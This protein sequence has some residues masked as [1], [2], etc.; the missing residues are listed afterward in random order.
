[1]FDYTYDPDEEER[2]R[3]LLGGL[4]GGSGFSITPQSEPSAAPSEAP[5]GA[6]QLQAPDTSFMQQSGP[7]GYRPPPAAAPEFMQRVQSGHEFGV[8]DIAM[9]GG[10]LAALLGG[11]KNGGSIAGA[12]AGS[13]GQGIIGEM[14]NRNQRNAEIDQYNNKLAN[15]NTEYDRWKADQ[16]AQLAFGNLEARKRGM[17]NDEAREKRIAER[18]AQQDDPESELNRGEVTQAER[19]ARARSGVSIEEA[20]KRAD[21]EL[22]QRK[23]LT[24]LL[25]KGGSA[26]AGHAAPAGKG[27]AK[28]PKEL[29]PEQALKRKLA[30]NA[31]RGMED[32]SVDPLTGKPKL[33]TDEA[34]NPIKPETPAARAAREKADLLRTPIP[35]SV[36]QDEDAWNAA[37][38][39]GVERRNVQKYLTGVQQVR[40]SLQAMKELRQTHGI[41]FFGQAKSDYDAALT[42]AIG[43]FTQIGQSGVLNGGEFERYKAFIPGMGLKAN[44]AMRLNPFGDGADP[45]VESLQGVQDA[46][47]RLASDGLASVGLAFD[48]PAQGAVR[49]KPAAAPSGGSKAKPGDGF[50]EAPAPASSGGGKRTVTVTTKDGRSKTASLS[51]AEIEDLKSDPRVASVQ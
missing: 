19:I 32:G 13:Y 7:S 42:A 4:L 22:N 35:G 29:T 16:E 15:Q 36:V 49:K 6:P 40:N 12:L 39:S 34:G 8:G 21:I 28:T 11:G 44:D 50:S 46:V 26:Q 25:G 9:L 5:I 18:L 48:G 27:G 31:L 14:A 45:T 23:L 3:Q 30:E 41:E 47:E 20:Q 17:A 43:G 2:R 1:M 10:I 38:T 51:E 24:E 33:P 37:V